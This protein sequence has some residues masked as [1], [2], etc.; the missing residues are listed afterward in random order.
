MESLPNLPKLMGDP[1]LDGLFVSSEEVQTRAALSN[2]R[3]CDSVTKLSS[4]GLRT[5]V[6]GV[7]LLEPGVWP[8][9]Q[10]KLNEAR[11]NMEDRADALSKAYRSIERDLMLIGC[12]GV[13]DRL[14]DDVPETLRALR[15][16]GIQIWVLTGDKEETAVNVSFL[17]GHFAPGLSIVHVTKQNDLLK[18]S[19][20]LETQLR[21]IESTQLGNTKFH[22]GIVVDG[23]S[24]NFALQT[25]QKAKFLLLCHDADAV[26]CCRLTP[27]QKAEV[28]RLVKH[29]C[30]PGPI[31]CAIGDG[32][33]DVSMI[34]EADVGIGLYG[35]EGRQAARAADYVIGK[36]RFL[37][38]ALL[39]HGFNF[40]WRTAN[41]VLYFFYKNL[42]FVMAQ[43]YFGAFSRFATQTAFSSIYLLSY[44]VIMT[45][46]PIIV[47]G[48]LEM[49]FPEELL[50]NTPLLYR[51]VARNRLL[52]WKNFLIW[53][54]FALWHSAIL[55]FG[56][57]FLANEGVSK[58]GGAVETLHG[59]GSMLFSL[60]FLVV[61]IKL[62]LIAHSINTLLLLTIIGTMLVTYAV[63]VCF[64]RVTI[65]VSDGRNL[66]GIWE[67][68]FCGSSAMINLFGHIFLLA[69]A[70]V[71]D[72]VYK[73]YMD[74]R[75]VLP[76]SSNDSSQRKGTRMKARHVRRPL[77]T[78]SPSDMI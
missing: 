20:T 15:E 63:F 78:H 49:R 57:Y 46:L 16:A 66:L 43:A 24:L 38:R 77:L 7:R 61:T 11:T 48:I 56:C 62:L 5:L 31:T 30:S 19:T 22:Y 17:A 55:F 71:P 14:Q 68:L 41:V 59:F 75:S 18:C 29:S 76:V 50:L 73:V 36:F 1:L 26:L 9:L 10:E 42:V 64:S 37:K 32:A 67:N 39:F 27:M 6:E 47:Y 21:A 52:S 28:V 13:E 2:R 65:P 3:V 8:S 69:S 74:S 54:A 33:N 51:T 70:L 45:S 72:I 40:Y 60:I 53:N 4:F 58:P 23:Q 35:K 12:T 34:L 25:T 44:N